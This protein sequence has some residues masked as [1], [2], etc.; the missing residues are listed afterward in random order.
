MSR[1][2][3][4]TQEE[5]EAFRR[6]D[7]PVYLHQQP[8]VAVRA[9]LQ[10]IGEDL[11]R[12]GLLETPARVVKA[13]KEWTAGYKQDVNLLLKTFQDGGEKCDEM[14]IRKDIPFFSHCEHHMAPFFGHATVAYL[15]DG[16]VVGLSKIDRVVDMFARRLQVQERLT[17]QIADAIEGGLGA[18]GVGVIIKARHFCIESRGVCKHN[19]ET[20][21][22]ALR[23]EFREAAVRAEF[24]SL[25][26]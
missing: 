12:G 24:L 10:F 6:L 11:D 17:N 13:W 22:S 2:R 20:L 21:T 9:L 5:I 1:I 14:V 3:N 16:K 26:R 25:A 7:T 15:P 23:G 19:S 4:M 8:E 18:K